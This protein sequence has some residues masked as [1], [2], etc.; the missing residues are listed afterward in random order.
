MAE[1]ISVRETVEHFLNS[2]GP[3]KAKDEQPSV[4][5]F[6]EWVGTDRQMSELTGDEISRYVEQETKGEQDEI[7]VEPL[8]FLGK[9]PEDELAG[10]V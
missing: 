7:L 1:A 10:R 8:N 5:Q 2:L 4:E 3:D 6:M 9:M